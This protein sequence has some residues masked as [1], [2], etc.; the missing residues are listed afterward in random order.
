M[1][2]YCLYFCC[3]FILLFGLMLYFFINYCNSYV[4]INMGPCKFCK[5]FKGEHIH[6]INDNLVK[7]FPNDA[8]NNIFC[9]YCK[10]FPGKM[11]IHK[12][13]PLNIY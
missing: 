3:L 10:S 9:N 11:H 13:A 4:G 6:F 5:T 8:N 2:N 1:K 7:Y 12:F